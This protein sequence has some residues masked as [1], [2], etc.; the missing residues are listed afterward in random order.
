MLGGLHVM[1]SARLSDPA[2]VRLRDYRF[3]EAARIASCAQ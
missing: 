3:I 1:Q 2:Y